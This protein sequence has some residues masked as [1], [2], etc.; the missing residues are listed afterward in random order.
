MSPQQSSLHDRLFTIRF[1]FVSPLGVQARVKE[2]GPRALFVHC[3][4]HRLNLAVQETLEAVREV[5]DALHE[6]ARLVTFFRD[7]PKRRVAL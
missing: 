1:S 6:V 2:V 7:S 4:A 5:Y 3:T